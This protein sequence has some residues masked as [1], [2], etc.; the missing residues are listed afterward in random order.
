MKHVSELSGPVTS[1]APFWRFPR[2]LLADL[3]SLSSHL[4]NVAAAPAP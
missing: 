2:N 4:A 1:H 3:K